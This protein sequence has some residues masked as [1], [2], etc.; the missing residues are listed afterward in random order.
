MNKS[1]KYWSA[2]CGA[3]LLPALAEAHP[4]HGAGMSFAAGA[5]HPWAGLDHLMALAATGL[6]ASRLGGRAGLALLIV[7]PVSPALG[8]IGGLRGL[9]IPA[10]ESAILASVLVLGLLAL[11]PPRRLPVATAT[12]AAA[13]A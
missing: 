1:I 9:E 2:A 8:A 13:F 11:A 7:F 5:L 12:L 6:L 4:G 3:L 10:T